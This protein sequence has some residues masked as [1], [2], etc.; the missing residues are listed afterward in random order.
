MSA[1]QPESVGKDETTIAILTEKGYLVECPA[2]PPVKDEVFFMCHLFSNVP[3]GRV[4][5]S[6]LSP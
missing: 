5:R 2:S 3:H 1:V 6:E 4:K